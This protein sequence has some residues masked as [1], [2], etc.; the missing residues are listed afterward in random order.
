LLFLVQLADRT[1]IL[2][3]GVFIVFLI[4]KSLF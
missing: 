1:S 3:K 4:G 2:A